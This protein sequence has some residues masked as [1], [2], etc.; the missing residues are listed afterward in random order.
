MYD[1]NKAIFLLTNIFK[2][3]QQLCLKTVSTA[4]F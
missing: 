1:E 4:L 2:S 3:L